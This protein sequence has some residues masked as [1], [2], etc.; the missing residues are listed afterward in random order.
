M[1]RLRRSG[2]RASRRS[3][4]RPERAE[5]PAEEPRSQGEKKKDVIPGGRPGADPGRAGG[6]GAERRGES[7]PRSRGG[8][9]SPAAKPELTAAEENRRPPPRAAPRRKMEKGA[10]FLATGKRKEL[11]CPRHPA[12]RQRQDHDQ[13]A[14]PRGVLPAAPAPDDGQA[15]AHG[16]RLRGQRRRPR[17]ASTAAASAARP[18]RSDTASARALTEID[19]EL[20]G[21]LKR[22]GFLTRDARVKERRKAGSRRPQAAA[23]QQALTRRVRRSAS[24][25]EPTGSE[26]RLDVPHRRAGDLARAARD[27]SLAASA[28]RS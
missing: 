4:P 16:L 21:D 7:A 2:V 20:R 15:A 23:V 1:R 19:S 25:S 10:R 28:R 17:S 3:E 14:R 9:E 18:G 12:S 13:Q 8:R 6:S 24:S 22:R 26:E 27:A 11:D 5:A